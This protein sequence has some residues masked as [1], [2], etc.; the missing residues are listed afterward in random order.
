MTLMGV[1]A[2]LKHE[3]SIHRHQLMIES[4]EKEKALLNSIVARLDFFAPSICYTEFASALSIC[5]WNKHPD[6]SSV[7][8]RIAESMSSLNQAST[9]LLI[10]TDMKCQPAECNNC[11]HPCRLPAVRNEFFK[12]YDA[13][14]KQLYDTLAQLDV[15][16]NDTYQNTINDQLIALCQQEIAQCKNTGAR[17]NPHRKRHRARTATQGR[18][19]CKESGIE[20]RSANSCKPEPEGKIAADQSGP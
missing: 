13:A 14:G 10:G 11:S 17:A 6:F 4:I 8:R 1:M 9:D 18:F 12:L 5:E 3:R 16:V 19:G 7:R 15:F 2:T 20:S